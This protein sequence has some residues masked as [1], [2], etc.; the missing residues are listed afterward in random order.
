LEV[1]GLA[2]RR[3]PGIPEQAVLRRYTKPALVERHPDLAAREALAL[4]VVRTSGLAAP[5]LLA[6]DPEGA[7]VGV[8]ALLMTLLDGRPHLRPTGATDREE[9]IAGL[10]DALI[11]V[12]LVAM[13]DVERRPPSGDRCL[14]VQP[15]NSDRSTQPAL[16]AVGPWFDVPTL[17]VPPWAADPG[18]W[19]ALFVELRAQPS[20]PPTDHLAL[21]HRDLH[22]GNVLWAR[23]RVSGI[24]DWVN[25]GFGSPAADLARCRTNLA[26][27]TDQA[28]ADEVLA[29]YRDR[30]GRNL[31]DQRWWD[32][33]DLGGA[34]T[35][36][37]PGMSMLDSMV[38]GPAQLGVDVDRAHAVAGLERHLR[39]ALG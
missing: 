33:A 26:V 18:L 17:T 10:V 12:H 15:P 25:A 38:E 11:A 5:R 30:S 23:R 22:P 21:V 34:A 6:V 31:D 4:E 14:E 24:V 13:T 9:W 19:N 2:G 39:S 20:P 16:E 32:L 8:P 7:E 29:R 28:D 3:R 1:V 36:T 37:I 27:L 35:L